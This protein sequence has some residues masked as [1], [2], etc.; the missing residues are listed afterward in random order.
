MCLFLSHYSAF[1]YWKSSL[2]IY[3]LPYHKGDT[4]LESLEIEKLKLG[5]VINFDL[6]MY[7]N[8]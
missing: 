6:K 8:Y 7:F 3:Y 5:N 4:K 2:I 1:S